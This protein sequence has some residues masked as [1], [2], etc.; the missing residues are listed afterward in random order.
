MFGISPLAGQRNKALF[1]VEKL[2]RLDQKKDQTISI[3][4]SIFQCPLQ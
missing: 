1:S 2:E 4:N 3:E